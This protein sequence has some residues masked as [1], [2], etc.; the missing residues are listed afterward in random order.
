M[1]VKTFKKK[2]WTFLGDYKSQIYN[3]YLN[4]N[5]RK[6]SKKQYKKLLKIY[7]LDLKKTK[8]SHLI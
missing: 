3:K 8:T 5:I 4:K 1:L 6:Q 2:M 7:I